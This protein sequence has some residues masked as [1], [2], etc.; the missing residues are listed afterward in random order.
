MNNTPTHIVYHVRDIEN[1]SDASRGIWTK[2]GA[3]WPHK[4][5]KGFNIT[6]DGLLPLDGRLVVREAM[7]ATEPADSASEDHAIPA[8]LPI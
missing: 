8:D 3:A 6:L 5:A 1:D 4:D 7:H 2:I